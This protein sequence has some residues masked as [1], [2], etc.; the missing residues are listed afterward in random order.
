VILLIGGEKGGSG[1]TTIATNLAAMRAAQGR[2][3]LLIDTDIQG[4]ASYW[5]ATRDE[6]GTMPRVPCMQKF[7][8]NLAVEVRD[9]ERRY[10][11]IIIDAGGRDSAELRAGLVVAQ[12]AYIP[13]QA[14][15]FDVWTLQRMDELVGSAMGFNPLLK[16]FV[17]INRAS[18]NPVVA[19]SDEVRDVMADFTN[20]TLAPV[21]LRD[22][23]SY[24]KAAKAGLSVVEL[25]RADPKSKSEVRRLYKEV[26]R[27]GVQGD[28]AGQAAISA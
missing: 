23:I 18:P 13:I 25:D 11:D 20:L 19:E 1:K 21:T 3:V 27:E 26:Y 12:A 7:G 22:R 15:Q 16:A 5:A 17:V 2:D 8:R 9:L 14:S 24:R 6:A 10:Q 28:I 4:S